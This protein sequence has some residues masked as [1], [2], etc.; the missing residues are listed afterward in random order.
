MLVKLKEKTGEKSLWARL[1]GSTLV[2][3]FGD[4]LVFCLIAAP[5][6][7]ITTVGDTVNYTLFGFAWKT[8]VEVAV[9]PITYAAIRWVKQRE[10]Y[11]AEPAA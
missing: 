3:E 9:M 11:F 1:L 4:T 2:G 5:A 7:G 10:G 8:L 6:I